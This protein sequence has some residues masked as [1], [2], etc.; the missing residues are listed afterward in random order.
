M[1]VMFAAPPPDIPA[2]FVCEAPRA[3]DGD[4]IACAGIETRVRLLGIDAPEM[5]GHC[6]KHRVCT[7]GDGAA[8]QRALAELMTRGIVWVRP[9]A[10]D[11]FGRILARVE[12]GSADLSCAMIEAQAAVP[13]YSPISC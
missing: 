1:P 9:E 5:P 8:A 3:I 7:P 10:F 11:R 6:Q 12:A 2:A 13:R 4:T